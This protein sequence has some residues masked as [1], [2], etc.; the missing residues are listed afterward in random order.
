[1]EHYDPIAVEA[2]RAVLIDALTVL[3]RY[4]DQL[5][6]VG[7]WVPELAFPQQGHVGSL[8]VDLAIDGEK[9]GM[10][11]AYT[12]IRKLLL[13]AG[14]R[15]TELPSRFTRM[16]ARGGTNVEVKLDLIT[17]ERRIDRG[18]PRQVQEMSVVNLRGVDLAFDFSSQLELTGTLP[19]GG[20]NTV[21]V[22]VSD[23]RAFLCMKGICLCERKK[24][25]DAYDVYFTLRKYPGGPA[26]LAEAFRPVMG[27][28]LIG[29]GLRKLH[30]KFLTVEDIGPVWAAQIEEEQGGD[31]ELARRDAFERVEMLVRLLGIS[32]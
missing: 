16:V 7:G 8:D 11:N 12:T 27:H 19:E 2:S 26:A 32:G 3:G 9:M 4:A 15:T 29:E 1:M 31:R 17:G 10:D 18:R 14:Y 20:R 21:P 13:D 25:K 22:R 24:E 5:V 23:A 30:S 28:P 6:V